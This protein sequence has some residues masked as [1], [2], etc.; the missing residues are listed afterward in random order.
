MLVT[1][2]IGASRTGGVTGKGP[3]RS[4]GNSPG[5]AAGISRDWGDSCDSVIVGSRPDWLPGSEERSGERRRSSGL[6][7]NWLEVFPYVI[8]PKEPSDG[9]YVLERS[10][11]IVV[12]RFRS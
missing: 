10:R 7:R 4:E 8:E 1:P 12:A 9:Q 2:A 11:R 6:H 5:D 3:K